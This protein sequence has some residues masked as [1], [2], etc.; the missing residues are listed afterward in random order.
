ME[1]TVG[2]NGLIDT[3][4]STGPLLLKIVVVFRSLKSEVGFHSLWTLLWDFI[5]TECCYGIS[6]IL[7]IVMGFHS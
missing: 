1:D 2:I 6:V 4:H 7:K 3:Q 5:P